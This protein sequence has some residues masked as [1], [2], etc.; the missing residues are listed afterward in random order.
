MTFILLMLVWM[1]LVGRAE[2]LGIL[3]GVLLSAAIASSIEVPVKSLEVLRSIPRML[4]AIAKAYLEAFQMF[5]RGLV[6]DYRVK[7]KELNTPWKT[8]I[9]VFEVTITPKTIVVDIE[10]DGLLEHVLSK[11]KGVDHGK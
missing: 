1:L 2:P 7:T 10:E 8:V 5:K 6:G 11:S 3:V 4:L 9:E